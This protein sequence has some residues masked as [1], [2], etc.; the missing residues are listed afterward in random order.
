MERY[1]LEKDKRNSQEIAEY[2][3]SIWA[4]AFTQR[5]ASLDWIE[6]PV[7]LFPEEIEV[8]EKLIY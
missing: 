1:E 5:K 2:P 6:D 3:N 8:K 4:E 7:E